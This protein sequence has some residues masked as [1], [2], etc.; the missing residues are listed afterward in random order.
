MRILLG[1]LLLLLLPTAAFFL[2]AWLATIKREQKVA[3]T[4]P[5]WQDLPL[6]WLAICGLSLVLAGLIVLYVGDFGHAGPGG[7]LAPPRG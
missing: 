5:R 4:L 6:T 2:W 7:I 3:G 1:A